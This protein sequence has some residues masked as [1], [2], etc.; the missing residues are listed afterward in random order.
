MK[1]LPKETILPTNITLPGVAKSAARG[2][3]IPTSLP[4]HAPQPGLA[5]PVPNL[6]VPST[7]TMLPSGSVPM[8]APPAIGRGGLLPNAPMGMMPPMMG[9]GMPMTPFVPPVPMM[10]R[11]APM[12]PP[13]PMMG[14]GM[15]ILNPQQQQQQPPQNK[16]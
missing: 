3:T 9:R 13:V 5:G 15:P 4:Q 10:G 2:I 6:G 8:M 14:R 7:A 16:Q 11:G 12:M 1:T